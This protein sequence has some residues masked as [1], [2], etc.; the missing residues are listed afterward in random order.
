M[1]FAVGAGAF[2]WEARARQILQHALALDNDVDVLAVY[3]DL[4]KSRSVL[5]PRSAV[6]LVEPRRFVTT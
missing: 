5:S 1:F 4:L 6:F 2:I 3:I